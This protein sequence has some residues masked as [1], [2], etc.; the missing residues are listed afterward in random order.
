MAKAKC[1]VSSISRTTG[2]TARLS[3]RMANSFGAWWA[4]SVEGKTGWLA[5]SDIAAVKVA[6]EVMQ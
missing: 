3:A 2:R 5:E 6:K 4:V 1:S